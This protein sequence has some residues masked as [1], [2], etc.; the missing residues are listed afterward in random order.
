MINKTDIINELNKLIKPTMY[1]GIIIFIFYL[2]LLFTNPHISSS[3]IK[4]ILIL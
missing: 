2:N 4:L 1:I 3:D